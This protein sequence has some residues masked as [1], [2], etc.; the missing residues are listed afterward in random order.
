MDDARETVLTHGMY[1]G[2]LARRTVLKHGPT[3]RRMGIG[4]DFDGF[5]RMWGCSKS[6]VVGNARD[7]LLERLGESERVDNNVGNVWQ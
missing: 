5:S 4:E 6:L 7:F 1:L 3:W 2:I